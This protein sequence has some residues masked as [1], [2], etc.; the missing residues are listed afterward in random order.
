MT[1]SRVCKQDTKN[2]V[3]KQAT[4]TAKWLT[5]TQ[6]RRPVYGTCN[7]SKPAHK[8]GR[9]KRSL[10]PSN[11]ARKA[12]NAVYTHISKPCYK[13][14]DSRQPRHGNGSSCPQCTMPNTPDTVTHHT[15]ARAL[16]LHA[17]AHAPG[18]QR[19]LKACALVHSSST[20]KTSNLVGY[21]TSAAAHQPPK[22]TI[23]PVLPRKQHKAGAPSY[24]AAQ[25]AA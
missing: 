8:G 6:A 1:C 12:N 15:Q 19:Q 17:H 23:T 18:L 24:I 9:W 10:A 4:H 2:R 25:A 21:N 16:Q 14:K 5:E 20:Y 11:Q 3:Q 22:R 7:L 13:G